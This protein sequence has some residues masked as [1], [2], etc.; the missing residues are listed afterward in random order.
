MCTSFVT[1]AHSSS[2]KKFEI[3]NF[4]WL[5]TKLLELIS[6]VSLDCGADIFSSCHSAHQ[7]PY[8][9]QHEICS[10]QCEFFVFV[11]FMVTILQLKVAKKQF[12]EKLSLEPWIH[13]LSQTS[14]QVIDSKVHYNTKNIVESTSLSNINQSFS[15]CILTSN[16]HINCSFLWFTKAIV[17]CTG[18]TSC[19]SPLDVCYSQHLSF[20]HHTSISLVPRLLFGPS[21]VWFWST[22]SFA[23]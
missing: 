5:N 15:Q 18:I 10:L 6:I 23:G 17:C 16:I 13:V 8:V 11:C 3:I 14:I 4:K 2:T 21:D 20:L 1:S 12:F 22:Q 9:V 19:I 7:I